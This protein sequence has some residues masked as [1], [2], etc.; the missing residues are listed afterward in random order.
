MAT[1][2]LEHA[3]EE[4]SR[5]P[6]DEQ[7]SVAQQIMELL[8]EHEWQKRFDATKPQLR[9]MAQEARRDHQEGRTEE[10][11]PDNL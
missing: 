10:L 8:S 5:L 4:A 2:A 3:F 9:K 1:K 11:D 7:E 6:E